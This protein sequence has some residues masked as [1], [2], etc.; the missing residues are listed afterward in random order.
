MQFSSTL[1]SIPPLIAA[2]GNILLG[3]AVLIKNP[4]G[5][6]NKVW[7]FYCLCTAVWS[8]GFFMVYINSGN[9]ETA[10][11]WN[12]FYSTGMVLIPSVYFHYVLAVSEQKSRVLWA[13]SK[14]S[15]ILAAG[16]ILTIPTTLFNS[17]L[18]LQK[19]GYSP[20]RNISGNI[21][22]IT[23]P[24]LL[25]TGLVVLFVS[26]H[27]ATGKRR[28]QIKYG[29]AAAMVGFVFGST[30]FLPLYGIQIY[31]IGHIGSFIASCLIVFSIFRYTF[32]DIDFVIKKSIVYSIVT[33]LVAGVYVAAI[34]VAQDI[35][36][37]GQSANRGVTFL[38]LGLVVA[39]AVAFEPIRSAVQN[40]VD[41]LFFKT[42]Y[43]YQEAITKFSRMVVTILDLDVLLHRTVETIGKTLMVSEMIIFLKE[44]DSG[45]YAIHAFSGVDDAS[46][47]GW[48]YSA[49]DSFIKRL[50]TRPNRVG[51]EYGDR[52]AGRV[53]VSLDIEEELTGF[54]I[55]GDKRSGDVYS[56][57][58]FELLRTLADQL[59][60]AVEN[61]WLYR[62]AIT[63]RL[64]KVYTGAYFY[65]RLD[66]EVTRSRAQHSNLAVILFD[67][68]GFS[69]FS[70][71]RG[72][73]VS[74][75]ALSMIGEAIHRVNRVYDVTARIG[76]DE[77]AVLLPGV[78]RDNAAFT[79]GVITKRV[80]DI[81]I[82]GEPG[83]L[84]VTSGLAFGEKGDKSARRLMNDAR[85]D[86]I[87]NKI[88]A[89]SADRKNAKK[90]S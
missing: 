10:V 37:L 66:E 89:K 61:A 22:D 78:D 38:T 49:A 47:S 9:Y 15:Y 80:T 50:K 84:G 79:A 87:K 69:G 88:G 74:N 21:F 65:D 7:T 44:P 23:Y 26:L 59:S 46:I 67:V 86:L 53:V 32:M 17:G 3:A 57:G 6:L 68:D 19:W 60:I 55:L 16:I 42:R 52:I 14:I 85:L 56:P 24:V 33:A 36:N 48:R 31:P 83:L 12:K 73:G 2:I 28:I 40:I 4:K 41:R 70:K 82:D 20:V 18:V 58:D 35:L 75:R 39:V 45:D 43:D 90:L 1:Y 29:I 71:E 72:A 30:N 8:F 54:V 11:F 77:F 63:D 81:R 13:L 64:T 62:A 34:V 27:T 76:D 51:E 5:K 25:I